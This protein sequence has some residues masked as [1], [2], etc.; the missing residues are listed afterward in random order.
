MPKN[1]AKMAKSR[2]LDQ[3]LQ[4]WNVELQVSSKGKHYALFKDNINS[5]NYLT[6]L[7][8]MFKFKTCNHKFPIERAAGTTSNS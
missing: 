2:L 6:N 4:T 5:E 3:Y 8:N 7:P 1:V